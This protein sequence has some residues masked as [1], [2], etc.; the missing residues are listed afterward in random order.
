MNTLQKSILFAL[1]LFSIGAVWT[2]FLADGSAPSSVSSVI[3]P[4]QAGDDERPQ[5]AV[6]VRSLREDWSTVPD[7]PE[8]TDDEMELM[9]G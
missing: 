3:S 7:E 1:A 2:N 5:I 6:P 8:L 9:G 4:V